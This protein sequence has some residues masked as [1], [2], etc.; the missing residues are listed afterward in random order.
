MINLFK[1][2]LNVDYSK[3]KSDNTTLAKIYTNNVGYESVNISIV[4]LLIIVLSVQAERCFLLLFL[5]VPLTI[6]SFLSLTFNGV[7]GRAQPLLV[8]IDNRILKL[9]TPEWLPEQGNTILNTETN[10]KTF[11]KQF[12]LNEHKFST[13]FL[14]M[15]TAK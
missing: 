9:A 11:L 7:S 10:K 15:K 2:K 6:H 12:P 4:W 5:L 3:S 1:T 13:V 14:S 8:F